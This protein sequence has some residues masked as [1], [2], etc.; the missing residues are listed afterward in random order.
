MTAAAALLSCGRHLNG[1]SDEDDIKEYV[2]GLDVGANVGL[3]YK[4]E[5]G[6]NFGARYSLGLTD[7]N[8]GYEDGGTY[9]NNVFQVFVGY[10]F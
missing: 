9:K 2:K 6:L 10:F 1:E 4:L 7:A 5:G 3:G 8:D